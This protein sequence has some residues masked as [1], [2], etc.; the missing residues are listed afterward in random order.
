LSF[1]EFRL[2]EFCFFVDQNKQ[3]CQ[4]IYRGENAAEKKVVKWLQQLCILKAVN[5]CKHF[6]KNVENRSKNLVANFAMF[7]CNVTW[8]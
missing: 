2:I 6:A 4:N 1:K 8:Q 7:Y 3:P 5:K